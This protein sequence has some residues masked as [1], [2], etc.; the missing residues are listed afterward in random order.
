VSKL[1]HYRLPMIAA[2]A[3]I[4]WTIVNDLRPAQAQTTQFVCA[5]VNGVYTTVAKRSTGGDRPVIRW[6]SNDFEQKGYTSAKRCQEVSNRFQQYHTSGNLNFLTTGK[7]NGQPVICTTPQRYGACDKLLFTVRPGVSPQN[8]L[9]KLLAVRVKSSVR[10]LNESTSRIA[11]EEEPLSIS[12]NEIL[13]APGD[14]AS[15]SPSPQNLTVG[16]TIPESIP[17]IPST[18]QLVPSEPGALW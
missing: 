18:N 15:P 2:I 1:L 7:M 10:P 12:M 16:S 14:S 6:I 4:A 3:A 5:Q 11:N 8:T 9:R 17:P 13:S